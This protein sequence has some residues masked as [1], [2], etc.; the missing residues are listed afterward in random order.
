M[1]SH[2]ACIC[3]VWIVQLVLRKYQ[4]LREVPARKTMVVLVGETVGAP[5][6]KAVEALVRKVMGVSGLKTIVIEMSDLK[7]MEVV[8]EILCLRLIAI[9]IPGLKAIEVLGLKA[10]G[11]TIAIPGLRAI[12]IE[13][14][15][16]KAIKM[17]GLKAMGVLS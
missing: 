8:I 14:P 1:T 7:E 12:A 5:E 9:G 10:I 6:Q 16:L 17:S 3:L 15:D 11:V 4:Y 13:M 2:N